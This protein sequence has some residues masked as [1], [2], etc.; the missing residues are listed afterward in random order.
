M[1]K[2]SKM[3]V[4]V[5]GKEIVINN[6]D[7]LEIQVQVEN[8]QNVGKRPIINPKK[9]NKNTLNISGI[10]RENPSLLFDEWNTWEIMTVVN[11]FNEKAS[12]IDKYSDEYEK[13]KEEC[14]QMLRLQVVNS[15][16]IMTIDDF[17]ENVKHG[18]FTSYDGSGCFLTKD[19]VE[20]IDIKF[21]YDWIL[22]QKDKYKYVAWYNK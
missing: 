21:N 12:T 17:A 10:V 14:A 20:G 1:I 5:N 4:K 11:W 13:L 15:A 6:S 18:G 8:K 19:G 2:M 9:E 22:A 16:L 7:D 3:I